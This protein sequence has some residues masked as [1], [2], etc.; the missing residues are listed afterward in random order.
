MEAK[1]KE[2]GIEQKAKNLHK[3]QID[4]MMQLEMNSD[5]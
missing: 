3:S 2:L 1:R 4:F 5:D